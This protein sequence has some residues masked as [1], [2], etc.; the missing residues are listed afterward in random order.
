MTEPLAG[1]RDHLVW[2]SFHQWLHGHLDA[3]GWFGPLA[4]LTG[5]DTVDRPPITWRTSGFADRTT[6]PVNTI[7][8]SQADTDSVELE[9]GSYLTEESTQVWVEFFASDDQLGRMVTGD[10]K[11]LCQGKYIG[12]SEDPVFPV[13]DWREDP[14]TELF[15][16]H[17]AD[18]QRMHGGQNPTSPEM[19]HWWG[20][21]LDLLEE[22]P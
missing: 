6:I 14:P 2:E 12:R 4:K 19:R 10:I 22:R 8:V 1:I 3:L 7:I 5:S 13:M 9:V 15:I 18:V 11:A 21:A 20:V 16:G 17:M